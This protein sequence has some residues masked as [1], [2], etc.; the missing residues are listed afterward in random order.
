MHRQS[1]TGSEA[2]D[3]RGYGAR[4]SMN[5]ELVRGRYSLS[6]SLP[7]SLSLSL[8]LSLGPVRHACCHDKSCTT[9]CC[10]AINVSLKASFKHTVP[11]VYLHALQAGPAWHLNMP[12]HSHVAWPCSTRRVCSL[13]CVSLD[14]DSYSSCICRQLTLGES[15]PR[16]RATSAT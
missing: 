2:S 13:S 10:M 12:S 6:L 4:Q 8:S 3:A 5:G 16:Q 14:D 7:L 11:Y 15:M 1:E 9:L